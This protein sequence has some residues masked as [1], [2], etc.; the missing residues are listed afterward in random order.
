[1]SESG[2]EYFMLQTH[3]NNPEL[4]S[5]VN[6]TVTLEAYYTKKIRENEA[7]VVGIGT[8]VPG[9]PSLL[10]PPDS[11]NHI[12][13]GHCAPGCTTSWFPTEGITVFASFLHTH[14]TGRG[15]RL[16]HFR[17]DVELP[18]IISDDNF[19]Y[20]YQPGR[21]LREERK[22]FPGDQLI[23]RCV[24]DTTGK[25]GSAVIGGYGFVQEMCLSFTYFY[26]RVPGFSRC[27]SDIMTENYA[28]LIGVRNT[29]FDLSRSETVITEPPQDSGQSFVDFANKNIVWDKQ[30][31]EEIQRQ[32]VFEPQISIC[33]DY[34]ARLQE[35][36]GQVGQMESFSDSN[37][38]WESASEE[39]LPEE[40]KSQ[41]NQK[42]YEHES[43]FR[44]NLP[45]FSPPAICS[46][47][48]FRGKVGWKGKQNDGIQWQSGTSKFGFGRRQ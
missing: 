15:M 33:I 26:N 6:I 40:N 47:E 9:T 3:F 5:N 29:T 43:T 30:M 2:S 11:K 31:R 46:R 7:G 34:F 44:Q 27:T 32:H 16:Q 10:L 28:N 23:Q 14:S 1:M 35:P 37:F 19:N 13:M 24:H 41:P 48:N 4:L 36:Q 25:N 8:S 21:V 39:S 17:G 38:G 45:V 22:V 12:I 18:W 42:T 20:N